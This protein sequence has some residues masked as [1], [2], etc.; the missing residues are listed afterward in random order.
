MKKIFATILG[1]LF[2]F[3]LYS[4]TYN[5]Y[6]TGHKCPGQNHPGD[7][8]I[9]PITSTV[10]VWMGDYTNTVVFGTSQ[11]LLKS[12]EYESAQTNL[13]PS[14]LSLIFSEACSIH[15]NP[16]YLTF[17]LDWEG[18]IPITEMPFHHTYSYFFTNIFAVFG[19]VLHTIGISEAEDLK[20]IPYG[21]YNVFDWFFDP[22]LHSPKPPPPPWDIFRKEFQ[23]LSIPNASYVI[24]SATNL[25]SI[26]SYSTNVITDSNGRVDVYCETIDTNSKSLF[27]YVVCTNI[28]ETP[29]TN[30]TNIF[31]IFC[32][33]YPS[34]Y[35]LICSPFMTTNNYIS[36]VFEDFSPQTNITVYKFVNGEY[37]AG[38]T[39]YPGYGWGNPNQTLSPGEGFMVN[40][41]CPW[42]NVFIGRVIR[43]STNN[44]NTGGNLIGSVYP[45]AGAI[46]T[47]LS[48]TPDTGDC[49]YVFTNGVGYGP[50]NAYFMTF[51]GGG[52]PF[53]EIGQA[54]YY[55]SVNSKNWV[56]NF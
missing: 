20:F 37:E 17:D 22:S 55:N 50:A 3:S 39:Y 5:L 29:I 51:W 11:T 23:I 9:K 47:T 2:A 15:T 31:G 12:F 19:G 25:S 49:V 26:S 1:F 42:T 7:C 56:Q 18:V 35:S 32:G 8:E 44:L 10:D 4:G 52:S 13:L 33:T 48:L 36:E 34:G 46:D 28:D 6:I 45:L 27:F 40:S 21:S 30:S 43:S 54:V 53:L 24:Y 16:P 41:P 14:Y 38:N